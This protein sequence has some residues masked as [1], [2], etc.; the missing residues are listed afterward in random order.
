MFSFFKTPSWTLFSV[1][2][3]VTV[4]SLQPDNSA[5]SST[6]QVFSLAVMLRL[7]ESLVLWA[8]LLATQYAKSTYSKLSI[9]I[10]VWCQCNRISSSSSSS[11]W[12]NLWLSWPRPV[13]FPSGEYLFWNTCHKIFQPFELCSISSQRD[14]PLSNW[15]KRLWFSVLLR[16]S[17]WQHEPQHLKKNSNPCHSW[18]LRRYLDYNSKL[19]KH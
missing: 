4:L 5:E 6:I 18:G 12:Q 10:Q 2:V 7:Y 11:F 3:T 8:S 13:T 14:K 15:T 17:S 16:P 9:L 1:T 19:L